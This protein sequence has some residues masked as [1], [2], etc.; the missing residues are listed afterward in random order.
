MSRVFDQ[1]FAVKVHKIIPSSCDFRLF[2]LKKRL[3]LRYFCTKKES[4]LLVLCKTGSSFMQLRLYKYPGTAPVLPYLVVAFR[5]PPKTA[6]GS[7]A[8]HSDPSFLHFLFVISTELFCPFSPS[9]R[10]PRPKTAKKEAALSHCLRF[11]GMVPEKPVRWC[12]KYGRPRR[13]DRERCTRA[14]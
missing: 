6:H 11:D 13:P 5:F 4:F 7:P 3:F 8:I 2:F 12:R 9:F 10:L 14:R 1:F